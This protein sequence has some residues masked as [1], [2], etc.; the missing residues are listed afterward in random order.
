MAVAVERR[1]ANRAYGPDA[2][3]TA[4]LEHHVLIAGFGRVGETVARLLAEQTVTYLALDVDADRV[5]AARARGAPVVY[6]DAARADVLERLGAERAAALVV[7]L[8]DPDTARRTVDGV[9][10]RWPNLRVLARAHD[11]IRADELRALGVA[12]VVP[13]TLES[14]LSLAR[15]ALAATGLPSEAAVRLGQTAAAPRKA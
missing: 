2:A 10:R 15:S 5:R 14:S 13:E 6:G 3:D 4:A 7:T 12:E 1:A 8:D 11:A 9:R